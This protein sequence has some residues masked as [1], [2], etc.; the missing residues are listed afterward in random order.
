[1]VNTACMFAM[2]SNQN[3]VSVLFDV[4]YCAIVLVMLSRLFIVYAKF[5]YTLHVVGDVTLMLFSIMII[6]ALITVLDSLII[7]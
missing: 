4:Y 6:G 5:T 7:L 3:D 2:V 1:M